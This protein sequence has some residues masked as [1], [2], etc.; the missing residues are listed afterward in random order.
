[1]LLFFIALPSMPACHPQAAA[2]YTAGVHTAIA[3]VHS[4]VFLLLA[5]LPMQ[6]SERL[7]P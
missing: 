5:L 1:M 7:P 6:P 3:D 4:H 2:V